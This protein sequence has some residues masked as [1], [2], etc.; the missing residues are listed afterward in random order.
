MNFTSPELDPSHNRRKTVSTGP[1]TNPVV[2]KMLVEAAR[3][4]RVP[5]WAK[6]CNRWCAG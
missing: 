6:A 5:H 4:L 2:G 1:N 3:R